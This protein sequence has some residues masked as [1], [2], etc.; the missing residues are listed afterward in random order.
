MSRTRQVSRARPWGRPS[1]QARS[2]A[3]A[4]RILD[5]VLALLDR[6]DF[7]RITV[8]QIVARAGCSVGAFYGRFRDKEALLEALDELYVER[9]AARLEQTWKQPGAGNEPLDGTVRATV[10]ALV[11]FHRRHAGLVRTL[12][13][14]ARRKPD[15][16]YRQR[17]QRVNG[18]VPGFVAL[19]QRRVPRLKGRA[20]QRSLAFATVMVL[21]ALREMVLWEHLGQLV[22]MSDEE[23]I[24]ELT[25]AFLAYVDVTVPR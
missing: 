8:P 14:R 20:S 11:D 2:A 12:V 22:P 23:L 7:D 13:L 17:E 19:V 1:A 21:L 4:A 15:A 24:R 6:H 10:A 9:F 25:R 18:L 3:T 16:G 5:A